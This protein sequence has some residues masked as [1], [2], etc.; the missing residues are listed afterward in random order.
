M[1]YRA[2]K[3]MVLRIR[4]TPIKTNSIRTTQDNALLISDFCR[5]LRRC[6][7]TRNFAR[8]LRQIRI[9]SHSQS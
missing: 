2:A 6:E 9:A 5:N 3:L 8:E 7:L 4:F 1:R